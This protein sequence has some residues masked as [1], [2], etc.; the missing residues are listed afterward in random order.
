[1]SEYDTSL[2]YAP[3]LT[4]SVLSVRVSSREDIA[5]FLIYSLKNWYDLQLLFCTDTLPRKGGVERTLHIMTFCMHDLMNSDE[6][7]S[8][9]EHYGS[10]IL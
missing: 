2:A 7:T 10:S 6:I 3:E 5:E 4:S 1:M 8:P 9:F